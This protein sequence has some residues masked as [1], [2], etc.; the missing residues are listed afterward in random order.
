MGKKVHNETCKTPDC[1][2]AELLT[3]VVEAFSVTRICSVCHYCCVFTITKSLNVAVEW[4]KL[5]FILGGLG[6]MSLSSE[7]LSC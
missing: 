5:C 2:V 3:C 7:Q 1:C 4:L 6:F